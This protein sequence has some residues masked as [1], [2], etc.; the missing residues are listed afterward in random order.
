[1]SHVLYQLT[2]PV[3]EDLSLLVSFAYFIEIED[4]AEQWAVVIN[5]TATRRSVEEAAGRSI[6]HIVQ[7]IPDNLGTAVVKRL[8]FG[9]NSRFSLCVFDINL[10]DESLATVSALALTYDRLVGFDA[11]STRIRNMVAPVVDVV[12]FERVH[13]SQHAR[14]VGP[15]QQL[16]GYG[17]S[18]VSDELQT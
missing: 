18:A 9:S 4:A 15:A 16:G 7:A 6:R 10:N 1:M 8:T 3:G 2:Q 14:S 11:D 17:A 12:P 5:R 13:H